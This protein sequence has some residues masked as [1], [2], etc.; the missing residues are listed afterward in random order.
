MSGLSVFVMN[1]GHMLTVD[2]IESGSIKVKYACMS[3]RILLFCSVSERPNKS[4]C[5]GVGEP[6]ARRGVDARAYLH[7][8][9]FTINGPGHKGRRHIS[10]EREDS[11]GENQRPRTKVKVPVVASILSHS[12]AGNRNGSESRR[13]IVKKITASQHQC[14]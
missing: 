11:C 14:S 4:F 5:L 7:K 6:R 13:P 3:S 9:W 12:V 2:N 1:S 10:R 8:Q